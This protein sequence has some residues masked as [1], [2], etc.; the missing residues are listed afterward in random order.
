M[1]FK[2]QKELFEYIYENREWKSEIDG[3]PLP[4]KGHW[5]WHWCFAH[6]IGKQAYPKYKLRESNIMLMTPTQHERQ[7]SYE[8][9]RN[10]RDELKEK[11]HK[12]YNYNNLKL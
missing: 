7:E 6:I 8:I 2:N 4:R 10:K 12:E 1:E 9:F 11:Y 5:Q 3:S